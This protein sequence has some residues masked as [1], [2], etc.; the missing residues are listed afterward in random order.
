MQKYK[1]LI[2]VFLAAIAWW[3]ITVFAKKILVYMEP[4]EFAW[5]RFLFAALSMI[6]FL[7]YDKQYKEV[8]ALQLRNWAAV[9][10][11]AAMNIIFFSFGIE[12]TTAIT[13][14]LLYVLVPVIVA[15]VSRIF[16]WK[17]YSYKVY[18]WILLW[19]IWI[20]LVLLLPV[21]YGENPLTTWSIQWNL[22][23]TTGVFCFGIYMILSQR[24]Y[25]YFSYITFNMIYI[26]VTFLIVSLILLYTWESIPYRNIPLSV[27]LMLIYLWAVGTTIYYLFYQRLIKHTSAVFASLVQYL[28]PIAAIFRAI[29]LLWEKLT[30]LFLVWM[31]ITL[32]WVYLI[33]QNKG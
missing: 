9:S 22:L 21:I 11:F 7:L 18:I 29:P 8:T 20:V 28:Q 25:K 5:W 14:Q 26:L 3:A 13:S 24:I 32:G 31:C 16:L 15:V 17:R 30:W 4:I 33:N 19:L 10:I 23:V 27:W 2:Y 12:Q 6:P 1:S